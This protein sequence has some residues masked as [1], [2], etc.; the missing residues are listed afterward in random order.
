MAAVGTGAVAVGGR[1]FAAAPG[2][3]IVAGTFAG[4]WGDGLKAGV[5]PCYRAKTGGDVDLLA[6][7]PGD[8]I[9]KVMAT[10]DRPALD[11]LI[12]TESDVFQAAALGIIEKLDAAKMPNLNG[13]LPVFREPVEGWAFGFARARDGITYN[14]AKIKQPPST[15]LE[16]CDRVA[17]GEFGRGVMYPHITST[18]GLCV[19]WLINRELGGKTD[20]PGPF[21]KKMREMKPSILKYWT[22]AADPGTALTRG[23]IDIAVWTDGRTHGLVA[24]GAKNIAFTLP[25]P[26]SPAIAIWF[27]KVKNGSEAAWEYL[28]C[29]ADAKNQAAWNKF[30]PGY[31]ASHKDIEYP[32]ESREKQDPSALDKSFRNWV[33]TPWKD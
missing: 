3:K 29:A 25:A 11:V 32:P 10:R 20:D 30:F 9:Q 12:S 5:V 13:I 27:M 21:M 4:V 15:W 26:G 6:G 1:A 14:T 18:D 16:F 19:S 17:K 24:A 8:F 31:A 2:P 7:T 23:E 28:N 33:P 22:S